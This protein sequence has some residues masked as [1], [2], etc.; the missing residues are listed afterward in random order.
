MELNKQTIKKILWIIFFSVLMIACAMNFS[1]VVMILKKIISLL[2]PFILGIVIAFLLNLLLRPLEKGWLWLWRKSKHP[3][4]VAKA[5]RPVCLVFCLLIFFGL[6]FAVFFIIVPQLADTI[7]DFVSRLPKALQQLDTWWLGLQTK[8][9]AYSIVLPEINLGQTDALD[10]L[11]GIVKDGGQ[12][13]LNATVTVTSSIVSA[14]FDVIVGFVCSIYLLS[15]KERLCAQAK[16]LFSAILPQNRAAALFSFA[17]RVNTTFTAFMTG[18]I[19]EAFILGTLCLIGMLIFGFPYP[20]AI[21]VLICVS[22]LIPVFGALIG[23]VIGALLILAISPAQA[24]WFVVFIIVLQQIEGNVIYPHVVGKS[25]GLPGIW[26]LLAV[27]VGGGAFGMI[28]ML[29]AVPTC[30]LIYISLTQFVRKRTKTEDGE[31]PS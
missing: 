25:V 28:G 15:G 3:D 18:Q 16:K 10:N 26:V 30:S 6:L 12:A 24:F 20:L 19:T 22:A 8:F 5:K 21:A 23:T 13:L 9:D 2:S 4:R 11:L 31:T 27:T 17:D 29:L 14:V 7:A 1:A